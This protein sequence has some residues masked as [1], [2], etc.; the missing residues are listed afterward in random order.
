M[1]QSLRNTDLL[2]NHGAGARGAYMHRLTWA[3]V[4][5]GEVEHHGLVLMFFISFRNASGL[6]KKAQNAS[7]RQ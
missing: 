1:D 6:R 4:H 7:Q 5:V 3:R 2:A